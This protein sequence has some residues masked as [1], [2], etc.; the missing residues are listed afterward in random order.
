MRSCYVNK[1]ISKRQSCK[2]CF[3]DLGPIALSR[4]QNKVLLPV[5]TGASFRYLSIIDPIFACALGSVTV[6]IS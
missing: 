3:V 1:L 6:E 4:V 5:E 2:R